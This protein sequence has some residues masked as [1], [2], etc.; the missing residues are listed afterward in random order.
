MEA[1]CGIPAPWGTGHTAFVS[2]YF[3]SLLE[4]IAFSKISVCFQKIVI[5]FEYSALVLLLLPKCFL[6]LHA[7]IQMW[8]SVLHNFT[9]I[10]TFLLTENIDYGRF[11]SNIGSLWE[12]S[13]RDVCYM[14]RSKLLKEICSAAALFLRITFSHAV[15]VVFL[16]DFSLWAQLT[17]CAPLSFFLSFGSSPLSF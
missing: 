1:S 8:E 4:S 6:L 16:L 7:F 10:R 3:W 15:C 17:L 12:S 11:H 14:P 5:L 13:H 9:P 2:S